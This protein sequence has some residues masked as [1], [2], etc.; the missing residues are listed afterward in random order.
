MSGA[1]PD[2]SCAG[3]DASGR[4]LAADEH[5][6]R[7]RCVVPGALGAAGGFRDLGAHARQGA[8]DFEAGGREMLGKGRR[9]GAVR[10]LAIIG[11][12]AGSVA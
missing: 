2:A 8:L 6:A 5:L 12:G 4:R 3:A 11:D 1:V 10:R 7:Q 9:I